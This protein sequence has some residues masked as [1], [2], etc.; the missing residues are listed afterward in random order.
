VLSNYYR[1]RKGKGD[2][3]VVHCH[4]G[5]NPDGTWPCRGTAIG[6][7]I[8]SVQSTSASTTF[9]TTCLPVNRQDVPEEWRRAL[10]GPDSGLS[11]ATVQEAAQSLY[12]AVFANAWEEAG[13]RF[14]GGTEIMD[15]APVVPAVGV[16][17]VRGWIQAVDAVLPYPLFDLFTALGIDDDDEGH[18]LALYY[19]FMGC[20]GHGVCLSDYVYD[21]CDRDAEERA[22]KTLGVKV[23]MRSPIHMEDYDLRELA[24]EWVEL[25]PPDP[26]NPT[27]I[28]ADDDEDSEAKECKQC[29]KLIPRDREDSSEFCS[30]ECQEEWTFNNPTETLG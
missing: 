20:I 15:V 2:W 9:L 12:A 3:M 6:G 14:S 18:G 10:D 21:H 23:S 17:V 4:N 8:G 1:E 11:E 30:E 7:Q 13:G 19:L 22:S 24:D 25:H 28:L 5:R 29:P 27:E 16:E 26:E